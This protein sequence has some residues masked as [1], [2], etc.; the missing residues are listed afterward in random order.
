M[1]DFNN[2]LHE[3][4][5]KPVS[6]WYD[7]HGNSARAVVSRMK[8][9][10]VTHSFIWECGQVRSDVKYFLTGEFKGFDTPIVWF[11]TLLFMPVLL[12]AAPFIRT[13]TR[14]RSAINEYKWEYEQHKL[15]GP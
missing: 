10:G 3:Q 14:Y 9:K 5:T 12:P 8:K 2:Y 11:L 4:I 15:K 1:S 13:Y 6:D 7:P